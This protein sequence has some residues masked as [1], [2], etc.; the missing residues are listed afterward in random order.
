MNEINIKIRQ[1]KITLHKIK[2]IGYLSDCSRSSLTGIFLYFQ[3]YKKAQMYGIK[4]NKTG[5]N[6]EK[7]AGLYLIKIIRK[8]D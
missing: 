3:K 1:E 2:I 4:Y 5:K 7:R 8:T 6:K